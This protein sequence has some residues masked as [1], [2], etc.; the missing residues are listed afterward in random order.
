MINRKQIELEADPLQH[1]PWPPVGDFQKLPEDFARCLPL[2]AREQA[3]YLGA[4]RTQPEEHG[5]F[6]QESLSL[7]YGYAFG[8][9]DSPLYLRADDEME[10]RLLR[11]KLVL[12]REMLEHWLK[13]TTPPLVKDQRDAVEYLR[14]L[15]SDN[16]GIYH[17]FFDFVRD[18]MSREQ[19][20]QFLQMEAVRNEVVDDEVALIVVGMQGLMKKTMT[21]NLWDECGNGRLLN[22]HTYWL[23]RLLTSLGA[24]ETLPTYRETLPWF[25]KATSNSFNMMATRPGYKFRAYGS[26]LV[27]ESWVQAHFTRIVDGM[28]RVGLDG[29]D[30]AVYFTS[31]IRIDPTHTD[32]ILQALVHQDPA[33][34]GP[35][36][37]EV[38]RGAHTAVAAGTRLY[39]HC[40]AHF[41]AGLR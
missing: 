18:T 7:I 38:L 41:R 28:R 14:H 23:R 27:T 5:R 11:F 20:V 8:Y 2:S 10:E 32:E 37:A 36:I 24:M 4:L 9:P 12:E 34:T 15:L 33:L 22:F 1:W 30:V 19:M 35:E 26:F 39:E 25:A 3:E 13:P 6:I 31:H 21:S 16:P 29:R 40:L 17:P